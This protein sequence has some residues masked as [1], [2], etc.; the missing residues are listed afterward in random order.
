MFGVVPFGAAIFCL[1]SSPASTGCA[2]PEIDR[3][4]GFATASATVRYYRERV[5]LQGHQSSMG[6]NKILDIEKQLIALVS[7]E[8]TPFSEICFE[9]ACLILSLGVLYFAWSV[10]AHEK[11]RLDSPVPDH[12]K[13]R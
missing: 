9:V 10:R 13:R 12:A 5:I 7:D 6:L 3:V 2:Q 1:H 11:R 4:S 8:I